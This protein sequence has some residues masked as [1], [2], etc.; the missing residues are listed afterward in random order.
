MLV[1]FF[2]RRNTMAEETSPEEVQRIIEEWK[3]I[4]YDV[5]ILEIDDM[6]FIYRLMTAVEYA[7][8]RENSVDHLE[9]EE[10]TCRLCVLDPQG[11]DWEDDTMAGHAYTIAKSILEDS[12]LIQNA[13]EP[14]DLL[15]MIDAKAD[16]L[17]QDFITQI[18][19]V[20]KHAFSEYRLKDIEAMPIPVQMELF[21]KAKWM[22]E[23]LE[24]I[25]L[26]Y[27]REEEEG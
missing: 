4:Y 22:L 11:V 12:Y 6:F 8:I 14:V 27:S 1:S 2:D 3:E 26:T 15:Q 24:G 9:I 18:P 25:Q 19:L 21:V 20:I 10:K 5:H 23:N 13:E 17:S 7:D 16:V